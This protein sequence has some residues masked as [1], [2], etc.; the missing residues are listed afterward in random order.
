ML[1]TNILFLV[2]IPCAL[3]VTIADATTMHSHVILNV[4]STA[5]LIACTIV[6]KHLDTIVHEYQRIPFFDTKS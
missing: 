6:N 3:L 4:L 5:I 2:C 1:A